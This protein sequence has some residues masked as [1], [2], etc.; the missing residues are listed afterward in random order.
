MLLVLRVNEGVGLV[1]VIT[2]QKSVNKGNVGGARRSPEAYRAQP[3]S[4]ISTNWM[5]RPKNVV[6]WSA[7][8]PCWRLIVRCFSRPRTIGALPDQEPPYFTVHVRGGSV[9]EA[10]QRLPLTTILKILT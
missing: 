3:A 1:T 7:E 4:P 10:F 5:V 2:I 9:F 6:A 8:R